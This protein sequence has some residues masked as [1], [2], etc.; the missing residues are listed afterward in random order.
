[1]KITNLLFVAVFLFTSL[2]FSQ[3]KDIVD[4]AAGSDD[5]TTLV[6]AV[7]AGDLVQT[8]KSEG[9]FTVFAPTNEAFTALPEGTVDYLL[10]AENK[11]K[12]QS[13]LNYHVIAGKLDAKAL[14]NAIKKGGGKAEVETVDGEVLTFML[15]GKKVKV[16]DVNG[17]VATVL[18]ADLNASNGVIHV[19]DTVLLP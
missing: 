19:V 3:N 8:L 5:H 4:I 7:K 1:M 10:K 12:L 6:A 11:Q 2:G 13:V 17:N 18:A 15:D 9:P 16:K 14:V